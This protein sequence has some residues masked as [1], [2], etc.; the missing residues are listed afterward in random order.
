MARSPILRPRILKLLPRNVKVHFAKMHWPS[1]AVQLA[2]RSSPSG[3]LGRQWRISGR[4]RGVN[5]VMVCSPTSGPTRTPARDATVYI[6]TFPRPGVSTDRDASR[7]SRL[8]WLI[9]A[10]QRR[11]QSAGLYNTFGAMRFVCSFPFPCSWKSRSC[12]TV[13]TLKLLIV[14]QFYLVCVITI[15]EMSQLIIS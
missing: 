15:L 8:A 1:S 12:F 6:I 7:E 4:L 2:K 10:K 14:I 3:T 9:V 11:V 5:G 13:A